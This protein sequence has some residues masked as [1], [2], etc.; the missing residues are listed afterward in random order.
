MGEWAN[1]FNTFVVIDI[2]T[3]SLVAATNDLK[4]KLADLT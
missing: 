3:I 2:A 4:T 1:G